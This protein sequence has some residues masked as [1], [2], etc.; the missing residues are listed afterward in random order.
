VFARGE[1]IGRERA[2]VEIDVDRFVA[3]RL[4]SAREALLDRGLLGVTIC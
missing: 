4:A 2:G 3:Q 1:L